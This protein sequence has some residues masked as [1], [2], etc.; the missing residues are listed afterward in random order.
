M[1]SSR[2]LT[3]SSTSCH[4][5]VLVELTV[6]ALSP[7]RT[8]AAIWLRISARSGEISRAGPCPASRSSLVAM[9]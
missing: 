5:P 3:C 9:K 6:R 8:A 1:S 4:W 2:R 7:I